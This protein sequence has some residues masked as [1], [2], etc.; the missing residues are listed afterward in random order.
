MKKPTLK[1]MNDFCKAQVVEPVT[2]QLA[3]DCEL[4]VTPSLSLQ[5]RL[6]FIERVASFCV[7]DTGEELPEYFDLIFWTTV[8][9]MMSNM[10]MPKIKDKETNEE[11]L[12]LQAMYKWICS[13]PHEF[14]CELD[15]ANGQYIEQ[16]SW[17]CHD[18]IN[19]RCEYLRSV[20]GS[21]NSLQNS[22][23]D[24]IE[25]VQTVEHV[26]GEILSQTEAAHQLATI[27][28]DNIVELKRDDVDV[29]TEK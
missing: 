7:S 4:V 11:S 5:E 16:L 28:G 23:A 17:V 18:K 26:N 2:L 29:R 21:M 27:Y 10:P 20:V 19:S 15:N 12:D 14:I 13:L 3:E 22:V 25:Q 24:F 8:F 1:V 6:A 9:Q